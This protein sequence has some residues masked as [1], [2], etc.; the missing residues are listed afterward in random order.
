MQVLFFFQAEDGIRDKLVTGVQ[1]CALPIL[2]LAGCADRPTAPRSGPGRWNGQRSRLAP[3]RRA[4]AESKT[5]ARCSW[6]L[7]TVCRP[8]GDGVPSGY[9]TQFEAA[10][11]RARRKVVTWAV[12]DPRSPNCAPAGEG[13]S[14]GR[15]PDVRSSEPCHGQRA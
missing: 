3:P 1:T 2:A 13:D 9:G 8:T 12:T 4:E 14:H 15:V 5:A 11:S 7:L 10:A 6:V